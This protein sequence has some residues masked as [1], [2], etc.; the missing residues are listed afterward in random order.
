[1]RP[2]SCFSID[3]LGQK[4]AFFSFYKKRKENKK[5]NKKGKKAIAHANVSFTSR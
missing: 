5:E 2:R 1:M 4:Q 3:G